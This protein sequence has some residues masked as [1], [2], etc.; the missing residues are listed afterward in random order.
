MESNQVYLATIV[1]PCVI[2]S[3][4][5]ATIC[6]KFVFIMFFFQNMMALSCEY[7]NPPKVVIGNLEFV[8]TFD[9]ELVKFSNGNI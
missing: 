7:P 1:H 8:M 3:F 4:C 5:A 6:C 9:I 2:R